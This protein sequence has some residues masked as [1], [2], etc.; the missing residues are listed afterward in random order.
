MQ[1]QSAQDS[2]LPIDS[3]HAGQTSVRRDLVSEQT[4][5]IGIRLQEILGTRDAALF[6]KNNVIAIEI[7]LRVLPYPARR[8][9]V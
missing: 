8:R 5:E 6:L 3:G 7:A 9:R 1:D 4:V 2:D